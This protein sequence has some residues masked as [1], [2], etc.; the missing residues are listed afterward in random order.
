MILDLKCWAGDL[1]FWLKGLQAQVA[2]EK[3]YFL[4]DM[5]GGEFNATPPSLGQRWIELSL[6]VWDLRP[7]LTLDSGA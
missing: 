6:T 1:S 4:H 5:D 3:K 2:N 7:G